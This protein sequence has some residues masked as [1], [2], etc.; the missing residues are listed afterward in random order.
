MKN[1][2]ISFLVLIVVFGL[3]GGVVGELLVRF[4]FLKD[5]YSISYGNEIN[6]SNSDFN[7]ANVV[8]KDPKKVIVNQDLR[9]QENLI[10][11]NSS[12]VGFFKKSANSKSSATISKENLYDLNQPLFGGLVLTSDG[13]VMLSGTEAAVLKANTLVDYVAIGRDKKAY[14]LDKFIEDRK[15]NLFF[16][17]LKDVTDLPV[18]NLANFSDIKTGQVMVAVNWKN[19]LLLTSIISTKRQQQLIK[20]TDKINDELTLANTLTDNFKNGL[21]F[22]LGGNL[23]ALI[24]GN[25]KVWPITNFRSE[26]LNLLKIRTAVPVDFG[27]NYLDLSQVVTH[28]INKY[29]ESLKQ[30][31][32]L[33]YPD[34]THVAVV[35][36]SPADLAGILANDVIMAVDGM[37]INEVNDLGEIIQGKKAGD[38]ITIKLRRDT[39]IKELEI[40]LPLAK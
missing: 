5:L 14:L 9:V 1:I 26:I 31:G 13:W 12:M 18:R 22:D 23:L 4:Y 25:K 20:S 38:K 16:V 40:T 8:I 29:G 19:D 33:V 39:E 3:V 27:V 10:A 2:K 17:H 28:D 24:D 35:K 36:N 6:L 37:E 21:V 7:R 15:N 34:E 11:I 30:N 32:A